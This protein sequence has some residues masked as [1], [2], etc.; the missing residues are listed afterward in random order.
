MI[1][2][3][4]APNARPDGG[5]SAGY[6]ALVSNNVTSDLTKGAGANLSALL[7]RNW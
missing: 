5:T 6:P 1:W 7:L 2:E 3:A 4:A